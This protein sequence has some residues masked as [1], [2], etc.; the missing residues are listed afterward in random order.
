MTT[1]VDFNFNSP[2]RGVY[3]LNHYIKVGSGISVADCVNPG[4]SVDK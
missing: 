3:K 4:A 2:I 1:Q